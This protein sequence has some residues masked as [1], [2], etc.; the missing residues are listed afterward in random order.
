[1]TGGSPGVAMLGSG[2][3]SPGFDGA[4]AANPT[5]MA[6]IVRAYADYVKAEEAARLARSLRLRAEAEAYRKLPTFTEDQVAIAQSILARAR[7]TSD[8]SAIISAQALNVLL[9]DLRIAKGVRTSSGAPLS[10]ETLTHINVTVKKHGNLGLLRNDVNFT[11]PDALT[12]EAIVSKQQRETIELKARAAV[13]Q[14]VQGSLPKDVLKSLRSFADT[15]RDALSKRINSIPVGDYLEAKRFLNRFDAACLAL[16]KGEAVSYFKFQNWIDKG[17]TIQDIAGYMIRE[18]LYF[19]P[20]VPGDEQAYRVLHSALA[21]Y[22]V[23][24]HQFAA[25]V[26][27]AN[28]RD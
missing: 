22:D 10:D 8:E 14:A 15:T 1:V 18:G 2:G 23:E 16:E 9:D 19:A 7:S 4:G 6:E 20:A 12:Q 27:A 5:D 3:G 24:M 25:A 28:A 13:Q 21:A 11:W 26:A 17:K